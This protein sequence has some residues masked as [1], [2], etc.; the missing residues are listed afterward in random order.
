MKKC[1]SSSVWF[2]QEILLIMLLIIGFTSASFAQLT[3]VK[4]SLEPM[5]PLQQQSPILIPGCWFLAA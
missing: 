1:F 2:I 4:Q 3:G 5:Q